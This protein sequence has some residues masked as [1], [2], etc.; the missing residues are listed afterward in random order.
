MRSHR[1]P[2]Q[3]YHDRV[4]RRYETVYDDAY[5]QWHDDLTWEYLKRHLPANVNAPAVDLGCGSGK[6]GRKLLKSGYRVTFVD[7]SAKM[8]DE[9]RRLAAEMGSEHKADFIQADL[10]DLAAL[11]ADHFAFAMAMGEP[12]GLA[13]DPQAALRQIARCLAPGGIL[14]ATLD[15]RVA[16]VDYYLEKG[17]IEELERFLRSGRTHWLTR[18][19][20][21]RFE[22]HT[23]EPE[24]IARMVTMTGLEMLELT[25]KTVLPMRRHREQLEDPATR[26]RW[27]AVEKR[28]A[29]DPANL[30]RC[31]HLQFAARKPD[32]QP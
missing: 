6:W 23:F 18:D 3:R 10:M 2:N 13:A 25:G 7:L 4:A 9:A 12:I 21:E 15:N 26:R 20:S 5:W 17:Q 32:R 29:R 22:V 19:P 30:A 16:C 31:P 27:A 11:P 8:V 1:S 28:L 14:V 24:Q